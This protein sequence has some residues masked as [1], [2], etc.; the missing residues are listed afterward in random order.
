ME[1][2]DRRSFIK[3]TTNEIIGNKP[4]DY[5]IE[6]NDPSNKKLPSDLRKTSTGIGPFTGTFSESELIHLL[7]RTLFGASQSDI[8]YF[9]NKSLNEVVDSILTLPPLLPPPPL[10]HYSYNVN[11][12]DAEVPAGQTWVN[13]A[14]N[15]NLE[16]ARR[17]SLKAWWYGQ[18]VKPQRTIREKMT[19]FWHNHFATESSVVQ[20]S[21]YLYK[22]HSLLRTNC[23]GNFK[24]LVKQ[25]SIDPAMLV[26]L[27]GEDNT[28][29]APDENYGRELQELFTVGKDLSSH[30]TEDDV[31]AAAKVLTGWRNN[32]TGISS[33]FD[34]NKHDST[35][36]QFSSFYNN[37]IITGRSGANAGLDE[38]ND[39]INMIFNQV[40]VSKYICRKIY[41]F[42]VYY[43]IDSSVEQNVI[44]PLA[45]ILRNN[46]FEIKPVIEALL[47]SEHFYDPLN[48]S[49]M[50]KSP[51]DHII[52]ICRNFNISYPDGTNV[53]QTYAHWLYSQQVLMLIGQDLGDPPNVAGWAAYYEDPQFYELWINSDS[54]PK[55]NTICD[56]LIYNGYNRFSYLL[57]INSVAFAEQFQNPED[58]N[59]L[60]TNILKVMYSM[61]LSNVHVTGIKSSFLLSGQTSDHYWTDAWNAYKNNPTASN[62]TVVEARLQ[63]MLKYLCGLPEYQLC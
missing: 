32:R 47:K 44:L 10:N 16:G 38:L 61:E 25:V 5:G 40:E 7:R 20:D 51:T 29:T 23:L 62:K 52:G 14:A 49:C 3:N 13:A 41:R 2:V 11:L 31:K 8:L 48:K 45:S 33:Y 30:Y 26:Y 15:P 43:L 27:N 34:S 57:K 1:K 60:L 19:L 21:R 42:F 39:L 22:H 58:P 18:L 24:E 54:L 55:R 46:N 59:I 12:P 50:I 37:T 9:K 53:E 56:S 28:K 6:Y 63:A 36:K 35:N 4:S 17:L